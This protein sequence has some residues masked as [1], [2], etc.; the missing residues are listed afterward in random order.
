MK[1]IGLFLIILLVGCT[2][3]PNKQ[4]AV[5]ESSLPSA[6]QLLDQGYNH[7]SNRRTKKAAELFDQAIVLCEEQYASKDSKTYA[8]RGPTETLYYLMKA[9]SEKENASVVSPT[10]ADVLYLRGY[11]ALDFGQIE[12]AEIFVRRA[13]EM[14]PANSM[15]LSEL[16]HIHHAKEEWQA[17]FEIFKLSVESAKS[18]SPEPVRQQELTRAMR[19]VGFSLIEL[20]RLD[21]AEQQF[22]ACLAIDPNDPMAIKE[23]EYIKALRK[24]SSISL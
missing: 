13:I 8:A 4:E 21:E 17:A 1:R 22:K 16:G 15:Y 3:Q 11:A 2:S 14:S 7:L 10:C 5:S 12:T 6:E 24:S 18:Y 23:I 9:A 20:G 19:G